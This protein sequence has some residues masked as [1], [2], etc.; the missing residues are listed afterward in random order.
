M[1]EITKRALAASLKKLLA[2]KALEK[3]TV[4]DITDDCGVNRQTFYYH[5]SDIYDLI[6]WMYTSDAA[7]A[8]G[9]NR[10]YATWQVGM[11]EVFAYIQ[12]NRVFVLATARTASREHLIRYL[13]E[14]VYRLLYGVVEELCTGVPVREEDKAFLAGFY[15]FA[16]VGLVLDWIDRGMREPPE[17]LLARLSTAIEGNIPAAIERFRTDRT[18]TPPQ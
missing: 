17:Q 9:Q 7:A 13:Y 11:A 1:S 4:S 3:I 6:E 5:F 2:G 18:H 12:A 15:K 14:Q 10:T 16:F 8:I